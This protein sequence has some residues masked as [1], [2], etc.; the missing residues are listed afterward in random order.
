MVNK[1]IIESIP[2]LNKVFMGGL[3]EEALIHI[4]GP[5]QGGKTI[6]TYQLIY[7]LVSKGLGNG[8]II[9][10]EASFRNNFSGDF[11][12]RLA[13]RVGRNIDIHDVDLKQY[14]K[15]GKGRR[16]ELMEFY[17]Y[18]K[19][20]LDELN[21]V[22]DDASLEDA[23]KSF[24]KEFKL[25]SKR[26][27]RVVYIV[28]RIDLGLMLKLLDIKANIVKVGGKSEVKITSIGDPLKSPL[29]NFIRSYG[30]KF[31]SI[32]SL[33]MLVKSMAAGLSDLPARAMVVNLIIG[34]LIRLVSEYRLIVFATNH[35]S[36]NP[37]NNIYSFYGGSPIGYGFKYSFFLARGREIDKR[38][39][40][41]ERAPLLPD[42]SIKIVLELRDDGFHEVEIDG[43]DGSNR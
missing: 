15:R 13:S 18:F 14:V 8:L 12:N 27:K 26:G 31:I 40:V 10:T 11:T 39:L 9:D 6:L 2:G 43:D 17:R 42:K 20:I 30:V 28:N 25:E 29:S 36:R 38:I 3:G 33:G 5:Y 35:E 19:A 16:M 34:A 1:Y 22:Y 24:I 21:I 41:V 32:D 37:T 23:L 4:Y 7:E